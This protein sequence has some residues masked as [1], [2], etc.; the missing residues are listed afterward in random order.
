MAVYMIGREEFIDF[1][2][3]VLDKLE[4]N[5]SHQQEMYSILKR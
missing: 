1:Q 2:D 3:G 4:V 5:N